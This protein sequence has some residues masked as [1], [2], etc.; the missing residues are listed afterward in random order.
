M[1]YLP[2]LLPGPWENRTIDIY[3]N[4]NDTVNF[5]VRYHDT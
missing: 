1:I 5:Y 4:L 3:V 2:D